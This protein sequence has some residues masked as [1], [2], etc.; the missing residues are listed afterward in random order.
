VPAAVAGAF[1]D[2]TGVP[3]RRIPLTAAYVKTLLKVNPEAV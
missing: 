2:A 1:F 3:P